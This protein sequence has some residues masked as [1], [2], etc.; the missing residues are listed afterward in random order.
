[1]PHTV[2]LTGDDDQPA[3]ELLR[4]CEQLRHLLVTRLHEGY[5]HLIIEVRPLL[6]EGERTLSRAAESDIDW[7]SAHLNDALKEITSLEALCS[8]IE[9]GIRGYHD[10]LTSAVALTDPMPSKSKRTT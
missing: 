2:D 8:R 7:N 4:R 5:S 9:R 6:E 10:M 1:M 3:L